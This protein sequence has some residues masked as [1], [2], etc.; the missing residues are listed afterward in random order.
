MRGTDKNKS[1]GRRADFE[2]FAASVFAPHL[3]SGFEERSKG[4]GAT[5]LALLTGVPASL[6]AAKHKGR[7]FA[8]AF[9]VRFLRANGFRVLRLT[10]LSICGARTKIGADH[11][12]L[13]SQLF[14]RYE[15]T[16]GVV[17]SNAYYHNFAVHE[18]SSLAFVN[19]P[20][21]SAYCVIHPAWRI[22]G[23]D[24][25]EV[26]KLPRVSGPRIKLSALRKH[27]EF[28]HMRAWA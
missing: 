2:P 14:R 28:C 15:A 1:P 25:E 24:N 7:H 21:L 20:I 11:V 18:L 8:D 13:V 4:C 3:F 5:A 26:A 6:I 12:V 19:K 27:A 16:W 10:P 9:M 17:H 23:A 22:A